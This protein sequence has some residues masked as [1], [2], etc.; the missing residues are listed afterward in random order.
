MMNKI[1]F[2]KITGHADD[3]RTR[4]ACVEEILEAADAT[5]MMKKYKQHDFIPGSLVVEETEITAREYAVDTD[6]HGIAPM[7]GSAA[8]TLEFIDGLGP[9]VTQTITHHNNITTTTEYSFDVDPD[10]D[11]YIGYIVRQAAN[12][13]KAHD[14]YRAAEIQTD[15]ETDNVTITERLEVSH[16]PTAE[17][18]ILVKQADYPA[19]AAAEIMTMVPDGDT[20]CVTGVIYQFDPRQQPADLAYVP[21]AVCVREETYIM[22]ARQ[23]VTEYW[24]YYFDLS[25][26][27]EPTD[28]R[29]YAA[30]CGARE[31]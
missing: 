1:E 12:A 25:V 3:F 19:D 21:I 22:H 20:D 13:I 14:A 23:H 2:G 7:D 15:I 10:S 30:Y 26:D 29:E 11:R 4:S 8:V 18:H 31:Y 6:L 5:I 27:A 16:T 28:P 9:M 17:P 24:Q